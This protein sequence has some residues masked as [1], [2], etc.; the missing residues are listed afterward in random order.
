MNKLNREHESLIFFPQSCTKEE[1]VA[2]MLGWM[3]GHTR[4]TSSIDISNGITED[5]LQLLTALEGPLQDYLSDLRDTAYEDFRVAFEEGG[6]VEELDEKEEAVARCNRLVETAWN[7]L[8]DITDE[9]AKGDYSAIRIDRDASARSSIT[10]Y[11]LRSVDAWANEKYNISIFKIASDIPT[12]KTALCD[13]IR[14]RK[15][16]PEKGLSPTCSK[17]LH[18]TLAL[19]IEAFCKGKNTYLTDNKPNV[20]QIAEHLVE[21]AKESNKGEFLE[22]Q[23]VS[24]IKK[25][26]A[27]ALRERK[28]EQPI[29]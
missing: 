13:I 9:I 16:G 14:D 24:S 25:R 3:Q 10:R 19:L 11:T 23:K 6:S 7:Y 27:R 29:K 20:I 22:S 26:I 2:M 12:E 4:P 15:T 8:M 18:I 17:S 28:S 21:I 1:A 5:Q